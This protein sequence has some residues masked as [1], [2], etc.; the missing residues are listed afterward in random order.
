MAAL[1]S[2]FEDA[3]LKSWLSVKPNRMP[4]K[5]VLIYGYGKDK[6]SETAKILESLGYEVFTLEDALS[7]GKPISKE[8]AIALM[9]NSKIDLVMTSGYAKGR[10]YKVRRTAVDL[11]VPVVLDAN[12]A[13]EL[14]KAFA[15]AKKN[16]FEIKELSEYYG[17]KVPVNTSFLKEPIKS[18]NI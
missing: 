8:K 3:L 16:S 15:W 10:D 11:N 13:Y 18:P 6:L 14:S 12:L 7:I 2:E 5:S 9:K 17:I 4:E 1:G